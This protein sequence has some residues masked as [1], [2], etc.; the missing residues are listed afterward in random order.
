[1]PIKLEEY[2]EISN[3]S[4]K[5]LS[6]L[7]K[8]SKIHQNY[9]LSD[10]EA[11]YSLHRYTNVNFQLQ[12][13]KLAEILY[14]CTDFMDSVPTDLFAR[15]ACDWFLIKNSLLDCAA[16]APWEF[17]I[18]QGPRLASGPLVLIKSTERVVGLVNTGRLL[19]FMTTC[20]PGQLKLSTPPLGYLLDHKD[21]PSLMAYPALT[22]EDVALLVERIVGN[23][24]LSYRCRGF[25]MTQGILSDTMMLIASICGLKAPVRCRISPRVHS[26]YCGKH[27]SGIYVPFSAFAPVFELS[28]LEVYFI[29]LYHKAD[30]SDDLQDILEAVKGAGDIC[31]DLNLGEVSVHSDSLDLEMRSVQSTLDSEMRSPQQDRLELEGR[32]VQSHL[33]D[34]VLSKGHRPEYDTDLFKYLPELEEKSYFVEVCKAYAR[35]LLESNVF[36]RIPSALCE[37]RD[38]LRYLRSVASDVID[39]TDGMMDACIP[40]NSCI[41]VGSCNLVDS[42]SLV[43]SCIPV[44][45]SSTIVDFTTDLTNSSFETAQSSSLIIPS[46][47]DIKVPLISFREH[48]WLTNYQKL[49]LLEHYTGLYSVDQLASNLLETRGVPLKATQ[50]F[51]ENIEQITGKAVKA[52]VSSRLGLPFDANSLTLAELHRMIDLSGC[53]FD[54]R[55]YMYA[56]KVP[57]PLVRRFVANLTPGQLDVVLDEL[58]GVWTQTKFV[59]ELIRTITRKYD[60]RFISGVLERLMGTKSIKVV[61][62]VQTCVIEQLESM[63]VDCEYIETM[64]RLYR[65]MLGFQDR[66]IRMN[67]DRILMLIGKA[68]RGMDKE[69]YIGNLAGE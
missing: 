13:S 53:G 1:M 47:S 35:E 19:P 25:I 36:H 10:I 32:S 38:V 24:S 46:T 33:L 57:I 67:N 43:D 3:D 16:Q 60:L 54:L 41:P 14:H 39:F 44:D 45:P 28:A 26:Y 5:E 7:Q 40:M 2:L 17:L 49:T 11:F 58:Q 55:P 37:A 63:F 48:R 18:S 9:C 52:A 34:L 68:W 21:I 30:I 22:E 27:F 59:L 56:N 66:V 15:I 12:P 50:W 6:L 31:S 61:R 23:H 69:V 51:K 20:S 4:P 42:C 62:S 29:Y 8:Y 64:E 65:L